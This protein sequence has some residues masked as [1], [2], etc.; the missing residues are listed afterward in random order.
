MQIDFKLL[1][2]FLLFLPSLSSLL[3]SSSGRLDAVTAAAAK[4]DAP[5][6][7]AAVS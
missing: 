4:L 2:T 1:I 3:L 6:K 7:R 5:Q